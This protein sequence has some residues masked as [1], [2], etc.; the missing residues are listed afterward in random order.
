[1]A[2]CGSSVVPSGRSGWFVVGDTVAVV[3]ESGEPLVLPTAGAPIDATTSVVN[4]QQAIAI[5]P[6]F[7]R[8][9]DD[10]DQASFIE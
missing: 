10:G 6:R 7:V 1:M 8:S 2:S 9:F 5:A 3:G 4:R